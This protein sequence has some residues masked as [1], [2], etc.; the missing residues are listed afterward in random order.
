MFI[1]P[2][3]TQ[4]PMFMKAAKQFTVNVE[5]GPPPVEPAPANTVAPVLTGSG[6]TDTVHSV[7]NGTWTPTPAEYEYR[8][9][10]DGV[11]VPGIVASTYSP[12]DEGSLTAEVRA[13][14]ADGEWSEYVASNAIAVAFPEAPENTVL[15]SVTTTGKIGSA[16]TGSHGTWTGAS[17][18]TYQHQWYDDVNLVWTDIEGETALNMS[19]I[20]AEYNLK[21]GRLAVVATGAG[22]STPAYSAPYD[23]TYVAPAITDAGDI[24]GSGKL[25]DVHY[26]ENLAFTGSGTAVIREWRRGVTPIPGQVSS[27][28]VVPEG[29]LNDGEQLNLYVRVTNSGGEDTA[30]V[31]GPTL[32]YNIPV[33]TDLA[34]VSWDVGVAISPIDLRTMFEVVGDPDL[35]GVTFSITGGNTNAG[36]SIT[37]G[38][39]LIA[40]PTDDQTQTNLVITATNSG[41]ADTANI[42]VTIEAS[43]FATIDD[44]NAAIWWDIQDLGT[45]W[46]NTTR[47][48]PAALN[49]PVQYVDDKIGTR[50][51]TFVAGTATL[52][53]GANTKYYLEIA[54]NTH[55]TVVN[56][57]GFVNNKAALA[58][59]TAVENNDVTGDATALMFMRNTANSAMI[60]VSFAN[61]IPTATARRDFA[62]GTS[63]TSVWGSSVADPAVVAAINDYAVANTTTIRVNGV[64]GTPTAITGTGNSDNENGLGGQAFNIATLAN[65]FVGSF[66]G[67]VC[68]DVLPSADEIAFVEAELAT[69]ISADVPLVAPQTGD[70]SLAS[71]GAVTGDVLTATV[72]FPSGMGVTGVEYAVGAGGAWVDSGLAASGSFSI[73][74]P[75]WETSTLIRLRWERGSDR[76]DEASK[77]ATPQFSSTCR[78]VSPSGNN[79]AAGT[80]AAPWQTLVKA[81][82]TATA[83]QTVYALPGTY[84][85]FAIANSGTTDQWIKFTTLPGQ[86]HQAIITGAGTGG[87]GNVVTG[88]GAVGKSWVWI[89]GLRFANITGG[90]GISF[91]ATNHS[92]P[93]SHIRVTDN[94]IDTCS[95]A[96][97]YIGGMIMQP[98]NTVPKDVYTISDI[99]VYDN[100]ITNTNFSSGGNEC[101]SIG[102]GAERI[103]IR[104]NLVHD[105]QQYG[106]DLKLGAR[107]F[108]ISDNIVH[109]ME[110]HGIYLD[111]AC[112]TLENGKIFRNRCYDNGD[113]GM[114]LA[115]E[116]DRGDDAKP[117]GGVHGFYQN[118]R[119]IDIYLNE[120]VR[121]RR[122]FLGYKHSADIQ[123]LRVDYDGATT[124]GFDDGDTVTSS[125]GKT[126][127]VVAHY[128]LTSTTGILYLDTVSAGGTI[129]NN[130]SITCPGGAA[131]V[132]GTPFNRYPGDFSNIRV[133][134]NTF[135]D[136]R[137]VEPGGEGLELSGLQT[138]A[139]SILLANN[140]VQGNPD[141]VINQFTSSTDYVAAGGTTNLGYLTSNPTFADRN[142]APPNLNIT[143]G[144]STAD[145]AGSNTYNIGTLF[146]VPNVDIN[147]NAFAN[148]PACGA[149]EAA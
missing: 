47:T 23:I 32:T 144:A 91:F 62:Q 15:P 57:P 51:L 133:V 52:R 45:L 84:A 48:T 89:D 110:K 104:R 71:A 36:A 61:G 109:H 1:K 139:Q 138:I 63:N 75:T 99:E 42:P 90:T 135:I 98:N 108:E 34:P 122:G 16:V 132:N 40:T 94:Q 46:A 105:S 113:N 5:S 92:T 8:W 60:G 38:Y 2:P 19:S 69:L 134:H 4:Q 97:I 116:A 18:Y 39:V 95:N 66:Y 59:F 112:R 102:N 119:N 29:V 146:G 26:H 129:A 11:G 121:N 67:A 14:V 145:G 118:I 56:G 37:G 123:L 55:F 22:G 96:G 143:A 20:A 86:R 77:S 140:I 124:T 53:Q 30:I 21:Q 41:G 82:A 68:F 141:G 149:R 24:T 142:A 93:I 49:G 33:G 44:T 35:S 3:G 6:V 74:C 128:P 101:I 79:A 85:A 114:T 100:N 125:G 31:N 70:W 76:S 148:P 13:R 72:T 7:S 9:K 50:D 58:L 65:D 27:E 88:G 78:F 127:R 25:G 106:I 81:G 80:Y 17:S 64:A 115:R 136:S 103:Y 137:D 12:D 54:T 111:C 147:G 107:D 117:G 73:T 43:T 120:V 28:I 83:G 126:G 10:Q 87:Q 130:Q 131:F